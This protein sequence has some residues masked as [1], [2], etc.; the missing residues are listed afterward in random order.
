MVTIKYYQ[1]P[2]CVNY[3]ETHYNDVM[4][5][6]IHNNFSKEEL[7]DLRFFRDEI[8]SQELDSSD[9]DFLSINDGVISVT[10]DSMIPRG[11][12]TWIYLA[13][14]AVVAI[15]TIALIPKPK[16][17]LDNQSSSTNSLGS[18]KNEPRINERIDDIFGKITKHTPPLWQVPYRTGVNDQETETLLLCIG[19]GKYLLDKNKIYDG[20][21]RLLD[22]PNAKFAR[23]EPDT[24]P[25]NGSP[26]LQIGDDIN[27]KIG[28]YKQSNDLNP[29]ELL[30]PNEL[31]NSN[32]K[33]ELTGTGLVGTMKATSIPDDFDFVDYYKVGDEVSLIGVN[34][35][36]PD[37]STVLY[38]GQGNPRNFDTVKPALDLGVGQTLLYE[39]TSVTVDTITVDIPSGSPANI[40]NAWSLMADYVV[41][42]ISYLAF[43][44]STTYF[45]T[46][47]VTITAVT[48]FEDAANLIP[49]FSGVN[50]YTP[51]IGVPFAN[52]LGPF[53]VPDN[54]TEIM[55]NFVSE[56][57]F[58]KL[59]NN[60]ESRV[61]TVIDITVEEI[62]EF[63]VLTGNSELFQT[64]YDSNESVR[65]SVFRTKRITLPYIRSVVSARRDGVRDKSKG[66]SNV[67]TVKWRDLYSFEPVSN[68]NFGDVTLA[69]IVIPSNSESRL[70]KDRKQNMDV[71]R[72]I[73]QYMGDGVFGPV[74]SFATDDFSQLLVHMSLDPFIGRL[75]LDNI[76]ADGFLSLSNQIKT[77]FNS[78]EMVKFGH[79]FDDTNMTYQDMFITVC[80]VV[81]CLPYVQNGIY[82]A[83]FEK[84]Q[85]VSSM[86][87]TCR[88]KI[89][90]SESRE[91]TF[92]R[93]HDGVEISYRDGKSS[94]SEVIYLPSDRSAT[95]PDRQELPGC[96]TELQA[97]RFAARAFNKQ[98][99]SRTTVTF[100]VDEF[101]RNIIPGKRIDSP[102]STRFSYREGAEDGYRVYEGEVV[103]VNGMNVELS[104]PVEFIDGE[105]HYIVFTNEDG[106]NSEYVLCT[107]I[108]SFNITL[109]SLPSE[110]IYDGYSRDRTKYTFTSEQLRESIALIPQTIEFRLDDD[111]TETN[112]IGSLTYT[113]KYY[114]DDL[115]FPQ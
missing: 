51:L 95:N 2:T 9:L 14:I 50:E 81:N 57:G 46:M 1:D 4:C 5:F 20:D 110:S 94:V 52:S 19:R 98:I 18:S 93:K 65:K 87:V 107:E 49:V 106:D 10:P 91:H 71:T 56:G 21:T 80:N 84:L 85:T 35:L 66:V 82:D 26:S 55:L 45:D 97:Y 70:I 89:P 16:A 99:Y 59:I 43:N 62:D 58:Y 33:W 67:D 68:L 74:E 3:I 24:Y 34:F 105:D 114:K 75:T 39:I 23:Y 40:L 17:K 53:V 27:E 109:G 90:S 7:L 88:N 6:L 96:T 48:W 63:G 36:E 12:E 28:I 61:S 60:N 31:V 76:N 86:Q 79:D 111:G 78:D 25:G 115:G 22:I 103:E 13:I 112:T 69:Q 54:A 102:D 8:L 38:D 64:T 29:S 83:F 100:D 32:I 108:D 15:A 77:Y 41:P 73:T 92:E 101:G 37:V 30:P 11:P 104:E 44:L 42:D 47:D 113:D 72:L